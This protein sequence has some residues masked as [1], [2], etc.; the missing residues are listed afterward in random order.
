MVLSHQWLTSEVCQELQEKY[1]NF[2]SEAIGT[3]DWDIPMNRKVDSLGVK[4]GSNVFG[5][6]STLVSFIESGRDVL[7]VDRSDGPVSKREK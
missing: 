3:G 4:L 2:N 1:I 5:R 6:H 7:I